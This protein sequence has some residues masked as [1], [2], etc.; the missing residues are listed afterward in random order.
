MN[1][2]INL[3]TSV[4]IN[5]N[6]RLFPLA[7]KNL[8]CNHKICRSCIIELYGKQNV[9]NKC[10]KPFII[11]LAQKSPYK[12]LPPHFVPIYA[13]RLVKCISYKLF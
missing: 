3:F 1:C 4:C 13:P 12:Y 2:L 9:C 8:S 7:T 6:Q 10:K 5:C 11:T